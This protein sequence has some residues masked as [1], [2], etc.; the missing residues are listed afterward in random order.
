MDLMCS[1]A[2]G[3]KTEA[4]RPIA[5]W[6]AQNH[7]S[8]KLK[9]VI[10]GQKIWQPSIDKYKPWTQWKQMENRGSITANH[11]DHVHVSFNR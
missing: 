8:L 3:V 1:R 6:V 2:G 9:Y 10:W 11:W 7:A 5:E 4:G